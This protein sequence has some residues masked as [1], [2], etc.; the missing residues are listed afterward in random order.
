MSLLSL[1]GVKLEQILP[2][3]MIQEDG[4]AP[5]TTQS[6]AGALDLIVLTDPSTTNTVSVTGQET[7]DDSEFT[8]SNSCLIGEK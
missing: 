5:Y 3:F 4:N 7:S 2:I 1:M 8:V 6:A